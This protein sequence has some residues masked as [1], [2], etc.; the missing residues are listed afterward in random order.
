[1]TMNLYIALFMP[2]AS[3]YCNSEVNIHVCILTLCVC[4][5]VHQCQEYPNHFVCLHVL[6]YVPV[7][8]LLFL[9]TGCIVNDLLTETKRKSVYCFSSGTTVGFL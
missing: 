3:S 8:D 6:S 1:M 2:I 9:D 4:V 7:V 5:C